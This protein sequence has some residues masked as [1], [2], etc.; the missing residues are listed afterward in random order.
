M[1]KM[2]R[3]FLGLKGYEFVKNHHDYGNLSKLYIDLFE[4]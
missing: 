4:H 1:K 3:D 2:N